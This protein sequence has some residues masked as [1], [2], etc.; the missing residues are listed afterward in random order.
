MD[1]HFF[2]QGLQITQEGEAH[3]GAAG[4]DKEM[5][6]VSSMEFTMATMIA[7]AEGL[8]PATLEEVRRRK[9]C[10]KWALMTKAELEV[11]VMILGKYISKL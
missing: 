7:E 2:P 11:F 9:D 5:V 6:E 8:D 10:L 4:M 3:V 1:Q